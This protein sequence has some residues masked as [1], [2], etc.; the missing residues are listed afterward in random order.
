MWL[1][2]TSLQGDMTKVN[3]NRLINSV[4]YFAQNTNFCGKVKLFKLLYL[5]DFEH[6]K[7]T[8]KSVTDLEYQAWELGPVPVA[9]ADEWENLP[10]DL[11]AAVAI[12]YE[13]VIS[14]VRQKIVPNPGVTFER[15]QLTPR[16]VRMLED[17]A[18]KYKNF[19]S[20]QMVELTHEPNGPWDKVWNG[21]LGSYEKIPYSLA[22]ENHPEREILLAIH[23]QQQKILAARV[24]HA[25]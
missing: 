6:F 13:P 11:S 17:L 7:A 24:N 19:T 5:L 23:E 22:V 21:S 10:E 12:K 2:F 20:E 14:Y 8:G 18:T 4:L 1:F 9:L 16:Q 15:D 3:R 25:S